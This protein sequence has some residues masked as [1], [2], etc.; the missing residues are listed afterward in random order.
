MNSGWTLETYAMHNEA[1]RLAEAR[2]QAERDRRYAEVNIEKEKALKIKET[3]DLAALQLAREIQTY[4]DEKAN[5]LREQIGSER[6]LYA[7]KAD[8]AALGEK[9][10]ATVAPLAAYVAAQQGREKGISL[11]WAVLMGAITLMGVL[12]Y[13]FS[14]R[15]TATSQAA[16]PQVIYVP[17]PPG[18]Q[19]TPLAPPPVT[20]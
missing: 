1:L 20:K 9:V 2:F 3:A 17:V 8:L 4:K 14:V 11:S 15:S 10:E 5:E 7:R 18:T 16:A 19:T 12:G 6:G 13:A